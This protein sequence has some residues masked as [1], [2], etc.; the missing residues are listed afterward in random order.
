MAAGS[1]WGADAPPAAGNKSAGKATDQ[2]TDEA[3]FAGNETLHGRLESFSKQ[4]GL[5]WRHPEAL[6][7]LVFKAGGLL[8]VELA[9]DGAK[10]RSKALV[11]LAN[12]DVLPGDLVSYSPEKV[13]LDTPYAGRLTLDGAC[14]SRLFFNTG[15][16]IV[17]GF[18]KITDWRI[19]DNGRRDGIRIADGKLEISGYSWLSRELPFGEQFRLEVA[20]SPGGGLLHMGFC[21]DKPMG[22]GDQPSGYFLYLQGNRLIVYSYD[23]G[24]HQNLAQFTIKGDIQYPARVVVSG[25]AQAK[26]LTFSVNGHQVGL[27]RNIKPFQTGKFLA[28]GSNGGGTV[29][30]KL[31]LTPGLAVMPAAAGAADDSVRFGNQ[32]KAGGKLLWVKEGKAAFKTEAGILEFPVERLVQVDLAG[33]KRKQAR[34]AGDTRLYF[35][36]GGAHLTLT[37]DKIV[38]GKAIGSCENLGPCSVDLSALQKIRFNLPM[39]GAPKPKEQEEGQDAGQGVQPRVFVPGQLNGF[40][41]G[42]IIQ[43][44]GVLQLQGGQVI[45]N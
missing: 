28:L 13:V 45:V 41:G 15:G 39:P 26:T 8:Q 37:L 29:Y 12:G 4:S 38:D 35:A 30:S 31:S 2:P 33:T 22:R 7:P 9:R 3:V 23:R 40:R 25:D 20:G 32:D 36:E 11:R 14:V 24:N 16:E 1:A 19:Q 21:L 6:A 17:E 10:F 34:Q 27:V 5:T 42:V 18:G 43:R 44:G